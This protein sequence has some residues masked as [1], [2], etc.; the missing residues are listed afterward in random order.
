MLG[1][2]FCGEKKTEVENT[3]NAFSSA[4]TKVQF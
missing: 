1:W 2:H 3:F 4:C